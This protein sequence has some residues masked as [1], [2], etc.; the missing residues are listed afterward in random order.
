MVGVSEL[1]GDYPCVVDVIRR[2]P[3]GP[4][5]SAIG[6]SPTWTT[7][8]GLSGLQAHVRYNGRWKLETTGTE[9]E[10]RD[11]QRIVMV[12]DL[13]AGVAAGANQLLITDSLQFTDDVYGS[14]EWKILETRDR[15]A[16]GLCWALC[17]WAREEGVA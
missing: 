12:A 4:A 11:D 2:E 17:E 6:L 3:D 10:L 5:R 8:A 16:D 9:V 15:G 14:S 13:P 7:V 1:R